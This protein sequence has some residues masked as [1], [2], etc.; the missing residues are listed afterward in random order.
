[1]K[2]DPNHL[3]EYAARP[4]E[5]IERVKRRAQAESVARMTPAER[6]SSAD[7]LRRHAQQINPDWPD[8]NERNADIENHVRVSD[9]LRCVTR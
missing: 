2:F 8:E 7:L 4:W 5:E 9:L 6:I 3:R 1:M